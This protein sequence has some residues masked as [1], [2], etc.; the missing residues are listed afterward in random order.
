MVGTCEYGNGPLG[1]IKCAGIS[2]LVE[3]LLASQE[4]PCCM[5]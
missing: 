4:G 2:L 3:G 1:S 5:E